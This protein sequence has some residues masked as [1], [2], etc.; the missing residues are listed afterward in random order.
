MLNGVNSFGQFYK[1]K[2]INNNGD[3]IS[4]EIYLPS[5]LNGQL[6]YSSLTKTIATIT[7]E[8]NI[9]KYRPVEIKKAEIEITN[10]KKLIFASIPEDRKEF[11]QENV[12]GKLS[13]LTLHISHSGF[14]APILRKAGKL[15]YLNVI[16][17]RERVAD[18]ISDCPELYDDWVNRKYD[19]SQ[20]GKIVEMYNEHF[21]MKK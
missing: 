13:Y 4:C 6:C 7:G 5:Y 16:N 10:N 3:T 20:L 12:V 2:I 18:L 21:D 14:P 11:F 9:K 1:G 19:F 15:I 8:G 17:K